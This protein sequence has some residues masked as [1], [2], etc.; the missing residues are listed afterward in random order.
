MLAAKG[1]AYYTYFK[2]TSTPKLK[3]TE[4]NPP[5]PVGDYVYRVAKIVDG[6]RYTSKD[7]W[8]FTYLGK[9]MPPSGLSAVANANGTSITLSWT[10][11]SHSETGFNLTD[12]TNY[13]TA[14]A[15]AQS[16]TWTGLTPGG[17][18]CFRINAYNGFG[19]SRWNLSAVCAT[20]PTAPV[21]PSNVTATVVTG[22]S[23][24]VDWTD[25]AANETGYEISDGTT[26]MTAGANANT[27]TWTGI[28]NGASKCFKVRAVNAVGWSAYAGN[29]CATT[30]TIPLAP[31]G[32]TATVASGTSITVKW[33]D[34]SAN[35]WGFEIS[36]GSTSNVVGANT[37]S[38]TWTGIPNGTNMCSRSGRTTWRVI[39]HTRR[40]SVPRPRRSRSRRRPRWRRWSA[41]RASK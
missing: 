1:S 39:R 35:E 38:F 15:N 25:N 22:T 18:S 12:G 4:F 19:A 40:M 31:T 16:F 9:P 30:P 41:A 26:T 21:A 24:R 2:P 5:L 6:K 10:D 11:L 7:E 34:K 36:N 13:R 27:Y 23:V 20:T 28:A 3:L 17:T 33:T 8:A 32:P 14:G 29:A 37:T